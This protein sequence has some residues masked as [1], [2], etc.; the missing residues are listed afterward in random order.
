MVKIVKRDGK[1]EDFIPE[2]IVVSSLKAG[3][4]PEIAREIANKIEAQIVKMSEM[5]TGELR[6]IILD[7]L[8]EKNPHWK[9]NWLIYDR[10]I[11]KR[12]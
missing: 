3:A 5:S 8:A 6:K 10:A 7:M 12:L 11:K 1:K 2:K 4:P 9:E